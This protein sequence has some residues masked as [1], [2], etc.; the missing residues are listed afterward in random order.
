MKDMGVETVSVYG[1]WLLQ[2]SGDKLSM[3]VRVKDLRRWW[4]GHNGTKAIVT[5]EFEGAEK[6]S[7]VVIEFPTVVAAE[8]WLCS[9]IPGLEVEDGKIVSENFRAGVR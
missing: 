3:A 8:K 4:I 6:S 2:E 1:D 9:K 7:K 5:L